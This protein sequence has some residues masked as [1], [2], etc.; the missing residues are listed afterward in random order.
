MPTKDDTARD[1][2]PS[3]PRLLSIK[4]AVYEL[5]I[6]RT[7]VYE[8]ITAGKIKTVK[9]GRRRLISSEAIEDFIAALTAA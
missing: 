6:S 8:Q 1:H 3:K 4:Q 2:E 5:G 9:I 7:A